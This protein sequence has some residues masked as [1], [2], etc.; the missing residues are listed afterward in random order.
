[1]PRASPSDCAEELRMLGVPGKRQTVPSRGLTVSRRPTPHWAWRSIARRQLLCTPE[2][3]QR[4][5]QPK[6]R[7]PRGA[8]ELCQSGGLGFHSNS[9]SYFLLWWLSKGS[10]PALSA[11]RAGRRYS[12]AS[13]SLQC[14]GREA[15]GGLAFKE[16][17]PRGRK[18]LQWCMCHRGL[19]WVLTTRDS[20]STAATICLGTEGKCLRRLQVPATTEHREWCEWKQYCPGIVQYI[21]YT[22]WLF[23]F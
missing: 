1:M 18:I 23:S 4:A 7:V 14:Q 8:E 11:P 16:P 15:Q 12:T 2:G 10:P 17:S 19:Q 5:R 20:G 3:P 13:D 6:R 9:Q 22:G 21:W